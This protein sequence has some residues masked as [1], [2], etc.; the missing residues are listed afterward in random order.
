[1]RPQAAVKHRWD[2]EDVDSSAEKDVV[3]DEQGRAP[4]ATQKCQSRVRRVQTRKGFLRL[5]EVFPLSP[6]PIMF[7]LRSRAR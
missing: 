1:M 3:D 2:V 4:V 7:A 5:S 6:Q